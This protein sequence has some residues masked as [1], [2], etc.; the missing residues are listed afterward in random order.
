MRPLGGIF[1]GHIGD[2]YGRKKAIIWSMLLMAAAT[3]AIGLLPVH[4]KPHLMIVL[5][6]LTLR[7]LQGFSVGGA[8]GGVITFVSEIAPRQRFFFFQSFIYA[9]MSGGMILG[10]II[11]KT[12]IVAYHGDLYSNAWRIPFLMGAILGVI[13]AYLRVKALESPLFAALQQRKAVATLPLKILLRQFPKE[14]AILFVIFSASAIAAYFTV[15]FYPVYLRQ[16][17]IAAA[18]VLTINLV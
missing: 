18:Q 10:L 5:L 9:G 8:A 16:L 17:G 15:I 4:V 3:T 12:A 6:L 7:L 11:G 1:F 2:R 13:G 14:V